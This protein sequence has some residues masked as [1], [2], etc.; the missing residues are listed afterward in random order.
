MTDRG[1]PVGIQ[2]VGRPYDDITTFQIGQAIEDH[3]PW[4]HRRPA[5]SII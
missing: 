1:L 2:I 4:S 5:F 3:R